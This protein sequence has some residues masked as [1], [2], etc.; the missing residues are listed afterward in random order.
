MTSHA[1][2][3]AW[4]LD[5]LVPGSPAHSLSRTYRA[6]GELDLAALGAAWREV[7]ARHEI[8]R[9]TLADDG[10]RPVQ[11][12]AA[13]VRAVPSYIDLCALA[14]AGAEPPGAPGQAYAE[15]AAGRRHTE[16][17]AERWCAEQTAL[18]FHLDEG[19]L[20]RLAVARLCDAKYVI[21]VTLHRAV[22]DDRSMAILAEEISACYAAAVAG[23]PVGEALPGLPFQYADHARRERERES[24]PEFGRLL[25]RWTS[26]LTPAPA[27]PAL[28]ADRARPAG[29]SPH[30]GLLRFD[31]GEELGADLAAL[32]RAEGRTPMVILLAAFQCLLGRYGREERFAVG[33]P[34]TVRPSSEADALIGPFGDHLVLGA[35][36]SGRP[37]FREVLA[38]VAH[39][40]EEAFAARELPFDTVVRTLNVDRDPYRTPMGD[41]M[42]VYRDAPEPELRL[43]GAAVRRLPDGGGS[44]ATD[45]TLT[46]DRVEPSVTGSLEYRDSLFDKTSARLILGQLRTLLAAAL[47]DPGATAGDLPLESPERVRVAVRDADLIAAG[48]AERPVHE[49]VHLRA[50]AVPDAVAVTWE[51]ADLTYRE[52]EER[53]APVTA[54]LRALG[55]T[56]GE[57]VAVRMAQGPRQV[58]T[59]LGVLDSGA[60]LVCLGTGDAGE[61]GKAVLGDSA[62]PVLVVDDGADDELARWYREELGGQVLDI[63]L[64]G[65]AVP[66]GALPGPAAGGEDGR[67][68]IAYTSGSTGR[69]KG[70]AQ[71][72]GSF[73]QFVTWF[74]REFDVVP[75][76]RMA[77]W[78][79]PGYDASL[80]EIFVALAAGA[81]LCPVPERTRANPEKLVAWLAQE[82]ITL[83][84][85]V[86]S[87]ARQILGVVAADPEGAPAL[88]HLLLAGEPLT[89]ELANGL[90]AALPTARLVNLYGPT[91][92]ILATWHEV[93]GPVYGVV[94]IGRPIPGRQVL[95]LDEHDR[96]CA[97]G[98]AGQIVIRGPHVTPGYVGA[99]SGDRAP[100]QP[101]PGF[102]DGH[103]SYR[104]GD[105][106]RRRWD[107]ALEFG[108]RKDFQV[109]FNGARME[110]TDIEAALAAH[111]SV[112][113][114]AVVAV[115]GPDGLVKRLVGYVVSRTAPDGT[116][117]GTA[118]AWRAA[119]RRRFGK[120]MPPVSFKTLDRLPRN[121]G[122]KVDRGALPHPAPARAPSARM[123]D[124]EAAREVVAIWSELLGTEE[125]G[126][127]ATFF[128]TGGH[129][130]LI[131]VLLDR[132]RGRLGT[133]VSLAQ[134]FADPTPG[135]LAALVQSRSVP[136]EAVTQTMMG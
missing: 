106:G 103:R 99:A 45:L 22:A 39:V 117:A 86:P 4:F 94:P 57:P 95:L 121:I 58:A 91:E 130:L 62:P 70:I 54:A 6:T 26:A 14:S 25:D 50:R 13:D 129:S 9:T 56:G 85:T 48:P 55:V 108:G 40:T 101:L 88:G 16:E 105:L 135:G 20:A 67:A 127:D 74:A 66:G 31:W 63:A 27:S 125:P 82:R 61:R 11:R 32:S 10:G 116:P 68:Y 19:P 72:H 84:Q 112:A 24:T 80:V 81:T 29:P 136:T 64:P 122:G 36:L 12:I 42:F 104:T 17:A 89:G 118:D 47:R 76:T 133:T 46:V 114:C 28:P 92:S 111:E 134:F 98:V 113:E 78:A 65:V 49:L 37:A 119:L 43:A 23:R 83:F 77:Q 34:V 5:R 110:L 52:L 123:P 60:H 100:F 97:P 35:D 132:I 30:G 15:Q 115:P 69:P 21:A 33:V 41:V 120:A 96:P 71:T 79:A 124:T 93:T 131:P 128:S 38:R 51:G 18:P 59:L 44:A 2:D 126:A 75:G 3:R 90:R 7:T 107:G 109:K 73:A 102:D 8:L 53:A 1:Q 87:F